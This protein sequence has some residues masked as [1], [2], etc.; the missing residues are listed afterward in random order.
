MI[1]SIGIDY[2][3][4]QCGPFQVVHSHRDLHRTCTTC[5]GPVQARTID[6]VGFKNDDGMHRSMSM[7]RKEETP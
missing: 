3:C 4:P 1:A 2:D 7:S 5:G 6:W